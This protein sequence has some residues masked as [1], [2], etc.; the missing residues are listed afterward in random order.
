MRAA[1]LAL[2]I[3]LAASPPASALEDL[4]VLIGSVQDSAAIIDA[5]LRLGDVREI[6]DEGLRL[7]RVGAAIIDHGVTECVQAFS[8]LLNATNDVATPMTPRLLVA[9]ERDLAAYNEWMPQCERIA[10]GR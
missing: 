9:L 6:K 10:F 7:S 5:G 8:A 1:W 2:V 3:G 4:H